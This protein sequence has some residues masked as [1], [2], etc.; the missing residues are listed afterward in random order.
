MDY[1]IKIPIK[2][3]DNDYECIC[4]YCINPTKYLSHYIELDKNNNNIDKN[5]KYYDMYSYS[6]AYCKSCKKRIW[7]YYQICSLYSRRDFLICFNCRIPYYEQGLTNGQIYK[8]F[9]E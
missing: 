5:T 2:K 7:H 8:L 1:N 4:K 6:F 9:T 3:K